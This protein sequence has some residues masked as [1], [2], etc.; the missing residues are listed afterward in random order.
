MKSLA[1]FPENDELLEK[2]FALEL[3]D[4]ELE[5]YG[6]IEKL[7]RGVDRHDAISLLWTRYRFN[8]VSFSAES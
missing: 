2:L 5:V 8:F 7:M 3:E 1:L 4:S 6:A